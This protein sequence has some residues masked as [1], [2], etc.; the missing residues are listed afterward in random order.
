MNGPARHGC[1]VYA[2]DVKKLSKFYI[3]Y[4]GMNT[5]RETPEFVA[6]ETEG[7]NLI[8]HVPPIES[9]ETKF[10][11]VKL[12][13]TVASLDKARETIAAY[14][15]SVMEGEWSN[16]VFKVCNVEDPEGNHI[17]IREFKS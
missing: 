7:F 10:S 5:V 8:V 1:I 14:G 12:F 2:R 3:Q 13:L 16:P 9:F 11:T 4:F 15:G 6:L 17:Q